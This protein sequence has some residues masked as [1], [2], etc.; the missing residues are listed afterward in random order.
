M[1][2]RD[3]LALRICLLLVRLCS[4]VVPRRGRREWRA[5]W[6]SEFRH[7]HATLRARGTPDWSTSLDLIRRAAGALP[8]AAWIRRQFTVDAEVVH[9]VRHGLRMLW[10]SPRF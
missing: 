9:D 6:Q 8:D 3:P 5:E 10:T 7:H 4:V 2:G 1:A